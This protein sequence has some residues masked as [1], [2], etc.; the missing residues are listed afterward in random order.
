MTRT[1]WP[2]AS[3]RSA[4]CEPINPL[5]PVIN[6]FIRRSFRRQEG[7]EVRLAVVKALLPQLEAQQAPAL[8]AE[9]G[10]VGQARE[11]PAVV[12]QLAAASRRRG[13]RVDR[14]LASLA[15]QPFGEWDREAHL[16]PAVRDH[17]RQQRPHRL[18]E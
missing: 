14:E 8:A 3:S 5:P 6:T 11:H 13:E 9:A 15:A 17:I 2:S 10:L 1:A 18:L 12:E 7:L 16:V 4:R